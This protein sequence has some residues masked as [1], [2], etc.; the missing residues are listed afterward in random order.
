MAAVPDP[1]HL[2]EPIAAA[3][4]AVG[5]FLGLVATAAAAATAVMVLIAVF[6]LMLL[7]AVFPVGI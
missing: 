6:I 2:E 7:A 3:T 1:T 5:G 4:V